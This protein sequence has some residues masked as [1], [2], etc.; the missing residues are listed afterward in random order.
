METFFT[1]KFVS[2][3][4]GI[5]LTV[6]TVI[7][8]SKAAVAANFPAVVIVTQSSSTWE[9]LLLAQAAESS[10]CI[11]CSNPSARQANP[12]PLP[13]KIPEPSSVAGLCL[14]ATSLAMTRR[15]GLKT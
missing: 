12:A 15:R 11:N 10:P 5:L 8:S 14:V 9:N 4:A 1:N 13:V 3:T 2:S 6:A 7:Y